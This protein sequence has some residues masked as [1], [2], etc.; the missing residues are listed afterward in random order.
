MSDY[1]IHNIGLTV[2]P[3]LDFG[4]QE[5]ADKPVAKLP[6][7]YLGKIIGEKGNELSLNRTRRG[8][9][10]EHVPNCV[11]RNEDGI[12]LRLIVAAEEA[13]GERDSKKER[14]RLLHSTL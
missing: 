3:L 6:N 8:S 10:E 1:I 12:A 7:Y 9:G 4:Q 5:E 2:S 14:N 11:L 13:G